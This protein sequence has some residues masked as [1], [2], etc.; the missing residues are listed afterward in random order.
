MV[1]VEARE[2]D[3]FTRGHGLSTPAGWVADPGLAAAREAL[4]A[5]GITLGA[6]G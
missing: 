6:E 5:V 2:Q 1:R 4:A 3:V